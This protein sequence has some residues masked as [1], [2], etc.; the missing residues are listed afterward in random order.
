MINYLIREENLPKIQRRL[1]IFAAD[2]T[3]QI[4]IVNNQVSYREKN[5]VKSVYLKN[6]NLKYFFK[7]LD[8]SKNHYIN[9]IA[10]IKFKDC[11]LV[12]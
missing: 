1:N 6:K 7:M 9:D 12:Q 10:F 8:N 5:R 11:S 2:D 3:L 4:E